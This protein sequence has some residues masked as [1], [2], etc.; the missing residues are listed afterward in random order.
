LNGKWISTKYLETLAATKSPLKAL[1]ANDNEMMQLFVNNR[2]VKNSST[3]ADG[4]TLHEGGYGFTIFF[5]PASKRIPV[6][7]IAKALVNRL[8]SF[9]VLD[10]K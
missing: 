4:R 7:P 1:E 2:D 5:K 8:F 9:R 10:M 6:K 3:Y